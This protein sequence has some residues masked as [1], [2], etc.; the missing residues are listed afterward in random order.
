MRGVPLRVVQELLGHSTVTMTMRYAHLAP[1]IKRESVA[2]LDRE[3]GAIHGTPRIHDTPS[4]T[5]N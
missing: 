5:G 1:Q 4:A 3:G 2:L